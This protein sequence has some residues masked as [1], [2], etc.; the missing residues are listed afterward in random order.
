MHKFNRPRC[1]VSLDLCE[2]FA[3]ALPSAFSAGLSLAAGMPQAEIEDPHHVMLWAGVG[4]ASRDATRSVHLATLLT[5]GEHPSSFPSCSLAMALP[6][7]PPLLPDDD[8][9][10][11]APRYSL[12]P[13]SLEPIGPHSRKRQYSDFGNL[14]SDP[15]FS[16][17]S[18]GDEETQEVTR[19]RRKRLVRG[20]WWN[21]RRRR[22]HD[23]R[24]KMARKETLKVAD[25]GVFMGSD[26]SEDSVDTVLS[27]QQRMQGLAMEDVSEEEVDEDEG[28]A[29]Q[30]AL[31]NPESLA[32]RMIQ[33]CLDSGKE[34][35]DLS[36]LALS[37]ISD[38]TLRPLH[39]LIRQS[40]TDLTRPPS[41]DEFSPLTP[42]IKLILANNRLTSLPTE[43][44]LLTNI[45]VLSLRSNHL[46]FLP[47]AIGRL[48]QLTE[49][50]IA[51]NEIT[52]LPWEL[53]DLFHCRDGKH[54][55]IHVRPNPLVQ[56][57]NLSGPSPLP[58][59][60][61]TAAER[62][63]FSRF[64]DT[65]HTIEKLRKK[66]A[67]EGCLNLRGELELR[68]KLGRMLRIQCLQD[69]SRSGDDLQPCKEEL[70]YLASSAVKYYGVDGTPVRL[71]NG[72][73]GIDDW[74]ASMDPT[75]DE[76]QTLASKSTPTL[77]ELCLQTLQRH[78]DLSDFAKPN[79][80]DFGLSPTVTAAL[81]QAAANLAS[82]GN[83]TCSTCGRQ[84]IIARAEWME[85]WFNGFPAQQEL[86]AETVLPFL[87]KACSWGCA[88]PSEAGTF[89]C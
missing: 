86:N 5:L 52:Y 76:P 34:A 46:Q 7:S 77:F 54:R 39:Q 60:N 38:A 18:T 20:P 78:C 71:A 43:L 1:D 69:A 22:S 40:F 8:D 55:Q 23:L 6:S 24:R 74:T 50:N 42:S 41:E 2:Q 57:S 62:E 81:R 65:R 33:A 4:R 31:P 12:G 26:I 58:R 51:G 88:R 3:S 49:L 75:I 53:L 44:F 87:R 29:E 11:I 15:V 47:S 9:L 79:T 68:L 19:P 80:P 32:G 66:Y 10:P 36:D 89:R 84:Y 14:S 61:F 63:D 64:A 13:D 27:S 82:V 30:P 16:D 17:T 25:S 70:I 85:Y 83:E 73:Q 56:P 28:I 59:P 72:Q 21:L 35:V 48:D 67:D 37:S 45:T